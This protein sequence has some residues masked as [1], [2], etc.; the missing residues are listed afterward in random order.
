MALGR[1]LVVDDQPQVMGIL[2]DMLQHL[3]YEASTAASAEDAIAAI[4]SVRPHV[5]ILDLQL[6]GM[7]GREALAYFREHYSTVPVI[8][9]TGSLEQEMA[10]EVRDRGAFGVLVKPFSLAAL[11]DVLAQAMTQAP[12]Q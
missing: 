3:Q 5:V 7:S 12:P 1:V 8:V 4:V 10:R 6:P 2:R 11:R 9:V